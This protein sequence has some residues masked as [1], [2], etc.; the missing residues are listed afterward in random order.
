MS[1]QLEIIPFFMTSQRLIHEPWE[2]KL[3]SVAFI[4]RQRNCRFLE[5]LGIAIHSCIL[6]F[7]VYIYGLP[8]GNVDASWRLIFLINSF[9]LLVH[10]YSLGLISIR[11][12]SHQTA[13]LFSNT[14]KSRLFSESSHVYLLIICFSYDLRPSDC[15]FQPLVWLWTSASSLVIREG[16]H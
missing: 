1:K 4:C 11:H 14:L 9:Y 2:P 6:R 7:H 3:K 13:L 16:H 8:L 15:Q 5:L 12:K 10:I